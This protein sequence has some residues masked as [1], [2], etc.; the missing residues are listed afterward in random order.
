ML[1]LIV[2]P[3]LAVDVYALPRTLAHIDNELLH[4]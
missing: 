4:N 1:Y 3:E 2:A